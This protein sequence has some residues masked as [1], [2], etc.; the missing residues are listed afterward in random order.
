M[1]GPRASAALPAR[2]SL[3]AWHEAASPK[4]ASDLRG[5][6]PSRRWNWHQ[7]LQHTA[8]QHASKYREFI[9]RWQRGELP[10]GAVS[11]VSRYVGR[12]LLELGGE[13]CPRCASRERHPVTGRVPLEI[14][15]LNG[16]L[17]R[18]QTRKF[19]LVVPKL[20][21][22]DAWVQ[23]IEQGQWPAVCH[24]PSRTERLEPAEGVEP[25]TFRLQGERSGH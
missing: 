17:R 14:D 8:C 25:S 10:G 7:V 20:P 1:E 9:E 3:S 4:A 11:Q 15:H 12:Y 19:A 21:R 24:C 6:R 13:Q 23:G 2:L 18:Q 16:Q 5:M 22:T